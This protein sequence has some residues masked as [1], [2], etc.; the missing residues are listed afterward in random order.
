MS[1]KLCPSCLR[2]SPDSM[3]CATETAWLRKDLKN[4]PMWMG[5]LQLTYSRQSQTGT[6]NGGKAAETPVAFDPDASRIK[7]EVA[8]TVGTWIRAFEDLGDMGD[9]DNTMSAWCGWLLRHINRIRGH[10]AVGEFCRDMSAAVRKVQRKV[11]IPPDRLFCGPCDVCGTDLYAPSG[12]DEVVCRRCAEIAG[13]DAQVNHYDVQDRRQWLLETARASLGTAQEILTAVPG[14]FGVTINSGT[15]KSW[16]S[17]DR[18]VAKGS[19]G[20]VPLYSIDDALT[21]AAQHVAGNTRQTCR[22]NA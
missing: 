4:L 21:L 2:P 12:K 3:L 14:M 19:R 1:E 17:R 8:N 10:E 20:G 7:D 9:L 13:P 6:G 16:V 11:D 22:R 18:L 15:F 5:Q